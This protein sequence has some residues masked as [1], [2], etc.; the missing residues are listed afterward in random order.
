[1]ADP[2]FH[3]AARRVVQGQ[4][5]QRVERMM[6]DRMRSGVM[7]SPVEEKFLRAVYNPDRRIG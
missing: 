3:Q 6:A 4:V 5:R 2:K 1:M 7:L